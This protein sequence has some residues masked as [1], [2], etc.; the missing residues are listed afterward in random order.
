[1]PISSPK[2]RALLIGINDYPHLPG[3]QSRLEGCIN[4]VILMRDLLLRRFQFAEGNVQ[5]LCDRQATRKG[6]LKAFS[7][8]VASVEAKDVVV[9]YFAGH[10]SNFQDN[11][12]GSDRMETIVPSDSGRKST[13][14]PVKDIKDM[15]INSGLV[16]PLVSKTPFVTLFFDC[17][18]SGSIFRDDFGMTKVRGI[19]LDDEV[20]PGINHDI[21]S[22]KPSGWLP[23]PKHRS[24]HSPFTDCVLLAACRAGEITP[25]IQVGATWYGVFTYEFHNVICESRDEDMRTLFRLASARVTAQF[26]NQHPV[27]EGPQGASVF[28]TPRL[29]TPRFLDIKKIKTVGG[30]TLV[31]MDGGLV[32]GVT[33]GSIWAV[34]SL[35]DRGDRVQDTDARIK[36][37]KVFAFVSHAEVI[38]Q[39][40]IEVSFGCFEI[41]RVYGSA[42]LNVFFGPGLE[43][44]PSKGGNHNFPELNVVENSNDFDVKVVRLKSR[45]G[46]ANGDMVPELGP[47]KHETWVALGRDGRIIVPPAMDSRILFQ[48]LRKLAR[49]RFG[50]RLRNVDEH[51]ELRGKLRLELKWRQKGSG[52]WRDPPMGMDGFPH[53]QI[54]DHIACVIT[55]NSNIAVWPYVL[56]F[57][58][59]GSVN[60]VYPGERGEELLASGRSTKEVA[61]MSLDISSD[62][63]FQLV[64]DSLLMVEGGRQK[65]DGVPRKHFTEVLKL[66]AS[67]EPID[68]S[69]LLQNQFEQVRGLSSLLYKEEGR[70]SGKF[71]WTV[72]QPFILE[73]GP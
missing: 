12:K 41:S 28:G 49:Y 43:N 10:G 7:D 66:F 27:M 17:C 11:S 50:L 38:R 73:S 15:E 59:D 72:E 31:E 19:D 14:Y 16:E 20:R 8:L 24:G 40:Q 34:R 3:P 47:L 70:R 1:M 42:A 39:G 69:L 36:V 51:N 46:V 58:E 37:K 18:H 55:N 62:K 13:G 44:F 64:D 2:K 68:L 61:K 63:S 4:D 48:N 29:I 65:N 25:E 57:A 35:R 5:I 26:P 56:E 32:S 53:F 9:V 71:W 33:C 67:T 30:V 52:P 23:V 21:N 54:D 22:S 60:H 45:E 6:I